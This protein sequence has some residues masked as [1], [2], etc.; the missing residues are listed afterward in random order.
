MVIAQRNPAPEAIYQLGEAKK[1]R[2][3]GWIALGVGTVA[4]LAAFNNLPTQQGDFGME[5]A[6][7]DKSFG[8][9]VALIAAGFTARFHI[10]AGKHSR[11]A[12]LILRGKYP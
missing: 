3:E 6:P 8:Y 11:K 9:G 1:Y 7:P 12:E 2:A 5:A 10:C 4:T